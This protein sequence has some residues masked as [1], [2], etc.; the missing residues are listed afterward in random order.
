MD[1]K[2]STE[3]LAFKTE[4]NEFFHSLSI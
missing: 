4:V 2:L 3:D 1:I